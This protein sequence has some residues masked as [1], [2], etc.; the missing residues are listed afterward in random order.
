MTRQDEDLLSHLPHSPCTMSDTIMMP[1]A[2]NGNLRILRLHR[3]QPN[4]VHAAWYHWILSFLLGMREWSDFFLWTMPSTMLGLDSLPTKHLVDVSP[5]ECFLLDRSLVIL[6]IGELQ[7]S[8]VIQDRPGIPNWSNEAI[9]VALSGAS[10]QKTEEEE[11]FLIL[12][13]DLQLP[14][15][16]TLANN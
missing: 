7:K 13:L 2:I 1:I 9:Y 12:N 8:W 16:I 3:S 4:I 5:L 6:G 11:K 15:P 10:T 14:S